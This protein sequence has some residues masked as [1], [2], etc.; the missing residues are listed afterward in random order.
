MNTSRRTLLKTGLWS[1]PVVTLATASPA[2]ATSTTVEECTFATGIRMRTDNQPEDGPLA[3]KRWDYF[4]EFSNC[5]PPK[6]VRI[7]DASADIWREA[8]KLDEMQ[9]IAY[10]FNDFRIK[11]LVEVD[12]KEF[13]VT[14]ELFKGE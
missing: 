6:K 8:V 9:W 13:M 10:D 1:A 11:R 7:Y 2:F 12:G 5:T 3:R 4:V 14:F